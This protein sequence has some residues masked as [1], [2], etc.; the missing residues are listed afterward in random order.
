[1]ILAYLGHVPYGE[2]H[3]TASQERHPPTPVMVRSGTPV[4]DQDFLRPACYGA[5]SLVQVYL[6]TNQSVV[7]LAEK[8]FHKAVILVSAGSGQGQIVK[9]HEMCNK[10]QATV[11][12]KFI[13]LLILYY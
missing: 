11:I 3:V 4:V 1:M 7:L 13:R 6:Y 10:C 9:L 5:S 2:R 8:R 12:R